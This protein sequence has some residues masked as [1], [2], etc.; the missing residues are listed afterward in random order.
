MKK[1]SL[2]EIKSGVLIGKPEKVTV[3][4]KMNGED[5]EFET[6]VKPF[7]YDSAVANMK[8]YGENKEALA[9]IIASCLCDEAGELV[10]TEEEIR[11]HFNQALV[12]AIWVKIIEVNVLGK[13]S[14]SIQTTNSL[15]K[16][17]SQPAEPQAKPAKRSPSKKPNNTQPTSESME[18][19]TVAE[20]SN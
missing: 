1:L 12:D 16:S 4:I 6:F 8:A 7:N 13:T 9:G 20:S 2:S 11:K 17:E 5:A 14:S 3:Q 10:L 19:S 15:S 18:A